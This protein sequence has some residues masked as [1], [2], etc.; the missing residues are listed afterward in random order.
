MKFH[1]NLGMLFY[2]VLKKLKK[3]GLI[4]KTEPEIKN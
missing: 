3:I 4:R 2:H 1:P